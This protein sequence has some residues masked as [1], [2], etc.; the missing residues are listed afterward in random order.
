MNITRW[1]NCAECCT[2]NRMQTISLAELR[3]L[4]ETKTPVLL[5][6]L[7]EE[8]YAAGHLPGAFAMPL[9]KLVESAARNAADKAR[10]LVVYCASSTCKNSHIAAAKLET[11]GYQSVHV[12]GGG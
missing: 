1:M 12:F 8:H 4:I 7:P 6:A 5:E 9:D 10:A 3:S 2:F 11:L